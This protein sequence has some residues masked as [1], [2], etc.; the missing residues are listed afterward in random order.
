MEKENITDNKANLLG[1]Q[2]LFLILSLVPTTLFSD[3]ASYGPDGP[4][5]IIG[6]LKAFG[7]MF[8]LIN[9]FLYFSN[10][11]ISTSLKLLIIMLVIYGLSWFVGLPILLSVLFEVFNQ[12]LF[13]GGGYLLLNAIFLILMV[14]SYPKNDKKY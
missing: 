13:K 2:V 11:K 10:A 4:F 9:M 6:S 3:G 5:V 14:L 8:A 1:L 12:G 7:T